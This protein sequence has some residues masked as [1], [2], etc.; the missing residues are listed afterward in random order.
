[1]LYIDY[2]SI[3]WED[4]TDYAKK[5]TWNLLNAYIDVKYLLMN[6][7][8]MDYTPYQDCNTNV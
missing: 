6:I 3:R 4:F 5:S 8:F 1:M 2:P 7:Q